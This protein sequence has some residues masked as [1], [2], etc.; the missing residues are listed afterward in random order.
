MGI[1]RR[2]IPT[3]RRS[4]SAS[5]RRLRVEPLEDRRLLAALVVNSPFDNTV[6]GDGLVTLRE[7]ILAANSDTTTDLGHKGNFA[8]AITFDF[9][10]DGPQTIQL[11]MGQLTISGDTQHH[12][13]RP[14]SIYHRCDG[15]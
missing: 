2:H 15:E 13:C 5:R 1:R 7:A 12:G 6:S 11:T 4:Q 14:R 10:H 9:G 8:D 3:R